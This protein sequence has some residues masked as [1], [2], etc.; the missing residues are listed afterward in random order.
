MIKDLRQ[1]HTQ[2][3]TIQ[4]QLQSKDEQLLAK[5]KQSLTHL[6]QKEQEIQQQQQQSPPLQDLPTATSDQSQSLQ[7]HATK[8]EQLVEDRWLQQKEA[9]IATQ[10]IQQLRQQLQWQLKSYAVKPVVVLP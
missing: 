5:D 2:V 10:E 4:L 1:Q 9:S 6:Q 3:D 7:R 8:D